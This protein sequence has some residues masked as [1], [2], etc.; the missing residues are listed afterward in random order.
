MPDATITAHTAGLFV[1]DD[2]AAPVS[3]TGVSVEGT[4]TGLCARVSVAQRYRNAESTPIEVVYLF[5]LDEGAAVCGFEAVIDGTVVVAEVQERDRAFERYDEALE[6]GHGAFL[7]DEERPDVF[8]ASIG[9]LLPGKEVLVRITYVTELPVSAGRLRFTLPTTIAPKYA[10][11]E[12]RRGVGRPESEAVNPP[13]AWQVPYGLHLSLR[14]QMPGGLTGLS[15]PS[16]PVAIAIE[17]EHAVVTLATQE[18]ALD[19]DFVLTAEAAVLRTPQVWV[20]ADRDSRDD[21]A[22]AVAFAPDLPATTCAAEIVFVVDRS[23]SM[24]GQS[25][26]EVRNALQLCLRAMTADCFFNVVGFGST[27]ASLFAESR[28]YDQSS[29]EAATRH[30]DGL[31]ADLG[32][33]EILPALQF[34]LG[35]PSR[36]GLPRQVVVLTDGE[37]TNTDAVIALAAQHRHAARVFT[38]GIGAAASQHLVKGLARAGGGIAEFIHPGERIEAAVMRQVAR[39]LSPALTDVRVEWVGGSVTQAPAMVPPIFRDQRLLVYGHV[40]GGM[41]TAVRLSATGPSGSLEWEVPIAGGLGQATPAAVDVGR[42]GAIATLAARARIRELEE[43]ESW[44]VTRG[45]QQRERRES[46][47]RQQIIESSVRYGLLSRETSFV[48]I[49]HRAAPVAGTLQL[50]RVPVALAYG[51]GGRASSPSRRQ[52]V[53]MQFAEFGDAMESRSMDLAEDAGMPFVIRAAAVPRRTLLTRLKRAVTPLGAPP[54]PAARRPAGLDALVKLQSAAGAWELDD[55][56]A[57]VIGRSVDDMRLAAPDIGVARA[58]LA[59]M[60]ATAVAIAWLERYAAAH[61]GEWRV[62]AI[63]ARRWLD[64]QLADTSRDAATWLDAARAWLGSSMS[65]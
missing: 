24:S 9:N 6:Q 41:P 61:E 11:A 50:R 25:I 3:L 58:A 2:V 53:P 44:Q 54:P 26:A 64:G 15:S 29:L 62:L 42:V 37:V 63:K 28:V 47:V 65:G 32:G 14:V 60:W 4:I 38:F 52:F 55:A 33:T 16:H 7:L 57:F 20:E 45:S 19:R 27:Y 34:V 39:L 5:P 49:E 59:R 17:G 18:A 10:P 46:A 36:P 30:V 40:T 12:D 13:V 56:L 31:D 21:M 51:W 43:S 23:G 35:Q 48:A 22:L 1:Q 8:R